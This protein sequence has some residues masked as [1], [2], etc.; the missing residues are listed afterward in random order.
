MYLLLTGDG[1]GRG[2]EWLEI[3]LEKHTSKAVL[4]VDELQSKL[5]WDVCQWRWEVTTLPSLPCWEVD[6]GKGFFH[7]TLW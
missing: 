7:V 6:S 4:D 2:A 1:E 3:P 5:W